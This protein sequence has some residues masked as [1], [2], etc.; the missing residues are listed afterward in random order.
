MV[1]GLNPGTGSHVPSGDMESSAKNSEASRLCWRQVCSGTLQS[2]VSCWAA[3]KDCLEEETYLFQAR[4]SGS[5]Q[6]HPRAP[7]IRGASPPLLGAALD[8]EA[9][10]KRDQ[11]QAA[12][13][14]SSDVDGQ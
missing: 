7:S 9:L 2:K 14:T 4:A 5:P 8:Q 6:K 12:A 3:V 1:V 13:Q 10:G 11:D